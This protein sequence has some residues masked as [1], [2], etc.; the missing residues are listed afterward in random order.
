MTGINNAFEKNISKLLGELPSRSRSVIKRRYG[1]G[2]AEAQT[3]EAIGQKEGITRERVRQIENDALAKLKKSP[4]FASFRPYEEYAAGVLERN[5]GVMAEQQFLALPEFAAVKDKK[6]LLFFFD[7]TDSLNRRKADNHFEAR[8]HT[9]DAPIAKIEN[10]VLALSKELEG[11][12]ETYSAEEI[13]AKLASQLKRV[14]VEGVKPQVL[15]AHLAIARNVEKNVW[16]EYGHANSPFVRPRGMRESAF[17]ALARAKQPLHFREIARRIGEFSDRPVHI[18]TVHNELIKD[19]RFVLVGRGLYA[20]REWGYEPGFIKD[21]L[22]RLLAERGALT[23]EQILAEVSQKRQVKPS[24]V[25][26]NLQ[27]KK[28]FKTLDDGTYTLIS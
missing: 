28:L 10:A 11:V 1:L 6:H 9:K 23:R 19:D 7:L 5:G 27:N 22:V 21:V 15:S 20:L 3:L 4:L 2:L 13:R 16:G 12:E 14:G 17:V 25:F 18:Q 26:I 8:W 24:T